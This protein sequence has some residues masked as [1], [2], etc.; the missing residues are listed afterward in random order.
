M[1]DDSDGQMQCRRRRGVTGDVELDAAMAL[2]DMA[3]VGP[4]QPRPAARPPQVR[5]N[6]P[7]PQLGFHP[8]PALHSLS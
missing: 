3:G 2:A 1:S 8:G 4:D 6:N 7:S 5:P